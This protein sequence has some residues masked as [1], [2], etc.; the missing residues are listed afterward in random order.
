M[1]PTEFQVGQ[2]YELRDRSYVVTAI[3]GTELTPRY[4]RGMGPRTLDAEIQARII[5]NM[6]LNARAVA[7][8]IGST[9]RINR[10]R[11]GAA[12]FRFESR[13]KD[14]R[15][16]VAVGYIAG[17]LQ[18]LTF[19]TPPDHL[20]KL[21][22]E[23]TLVTTVPAQN[24]GIYVVESNKWFY[25]S[26]VVFKAD[27]VAADWLRMFFAG[28]CEFTPEYES[29]SGT[30]SWAVHLNEITFDLLA[31]G[32]CVGEGVDIDDVRQHIPAEHLAEFERGLAGDLLAPQ[33]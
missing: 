32:F 19:Q 5:T 20:D 6:D 12:R 22:D 10:V 13:R 17:H 26:A 4:T 14:W 29:Q 18:G 7:E 1:K 3:N 27:K 31:L 11:P 9:A 33:V 24:K 8:A 16:W 23:L 2:L 28:R 30:G 25:S 21:L 15:W